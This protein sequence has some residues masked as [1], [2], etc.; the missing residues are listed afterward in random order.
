MSL[1]SP[2]LEPT[3]FEP[4]TF[5]IPK[6]SRFSNRCPKSSMTG[7][8]FTTAAQN[9][10]WLSSLCK[11]A[12][13]GP[14]KHSIEH[15]GLA[16]RGGGLMVKTDTLSRAALEA[17]EEKADNLT[18]DTLKEDDAKGMQ[19]YEDRSKIREVLSTRT[20]RELILK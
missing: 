11:E 7:N 13:R 4:R 3:L 5:P 20:A 6:P 18:R 9:R 8:I 16:M 1:A 2:A 15:D 17:D 19:G 14:S 12:A 10:D